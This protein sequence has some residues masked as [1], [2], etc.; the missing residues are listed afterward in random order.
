MEVKFGFFV[1]K[2][3]PGGIV[4]ERLRPSNAA[5]WGGAY[6]EDPRSPLVRTSGVGMFLEPS[7]ERPDMDS[8]PLGINLGA[9]DF[10]SNYVPTSLILEEQLIPGEGG[11]KL[12][13]VKRAT[14]TPTLTALT[15]PPQYGSAYPPMPGSASREP[16]IWL[17]KTEAPL[18][19]N[20]S[21]CVHIQ[22][23][24]TF[25][26]GVGVIWAMG[27][28]NHYYMEVTGSG[29][30]DFWYNTSELTSAPQWQ[31]VKTLGIGLGEGKWVSSFF[32]SI[33]PLGKDSIRIRASNSVPSEE[34]PHYGHDS[35]KASDAV[36]HLNRYRKEPCGFNAVLSDYVKVQAAPVYIAFPK[37]DASVAFMFHRS[38]FAANY[39]TLLAGENLGY[40]RT[41]TPVFYGFGAPSAGGGSIGG[42]FIDDTGGLYVPGS[43]TSIA[44]SLDSWVPGTFDVR[45]YVYTPVLT[46]IA[47][48]V[49]TSVVLRDDPPAPFDW[50]KVWRRIEFTLSV[51]PKAT[52]C[53]VELNRTFDWR[54]LLKLDAQLDIAF[55]GEY[56]WSGYCEINKPMQ[57][58]S[59]TSEP[60]G[61]SIDRDLMRTPRVEGD[62]QAT[63]RLWTKLEE[64]PGDAFAFLRPGN[65]AE[66]ITRILNFA[67]IRDEDIAVAD[68]VLYD[69]DFDDPDDEGRS[70]T[71]ASG[72]SMADIARNVIEK[73]A[74]QGQE[75]IWIRLVAGVYTI[76]ISQY[77]ESGVSDLPD[78][79]FYLHPGVMPPE[80]FGYTDE[81]RWAGIE[82]LRYFAIISESLDA[83]V[84]RAQGNMLSAYA[85]A[86]PELDDDLL[87]CY[88]V[89]HPSTLSDPDSFNF[90]NRL[91][92]WSA[93]AEASANASGLLELARFAR[94]EYDRNG[95]PRLSLNIDAEWQPGVEPDDIIWIQ[96]L[97]LL[98]G[99]GGEPRGVP[100]S[101]GAWRIEEIN[102]TIDC[103]DE[104]ADG[105]EH[106]RSMTWTGHYT[107]VY[108]GIAETEDMPMFTTV[109]PDYAPP[110]EEDEE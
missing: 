91:R 90:E 4:V 63:E 53:T 19:M 64:M 34:W 84:E 107:L 106:S 95:T 16:W 51:H 5:S 68:S 3:L 86:S 21:F 8:V 88:I 46:K 18:Y 108:A 105:V 94:K 30:V 72:A 38:R 48:K 103:D 58:G 59:F 26:E 87:A 61:V 11:L 49:P 78:V 55:D 28:G 100:V 75:T 1:E 52:I 93:T 31:K 22:P 36:I 6:G 10:L 81:E 60:F 23:L 71:G 24:G 40:P 13:E 101:Y 77:Y 89:P 41:A 82:G 109:V 83:T 2:D 33:T 97:R 32:L 69:M 79:V 56:V 104:D 102:V 74:V 67:G 37:D 76:G 96:G 35:L 43:S 47:Y 15:A 9:D 39:E 45:G 54:N 65:V 14:L 27:F 98:E 99:P 70:Y 25:A 7:G 92:P 20:E 80:E 73:Y 62:V 17:L 66:A 85:P 50:S 110:E 57:V 12:L 42:T 29:A 44:C